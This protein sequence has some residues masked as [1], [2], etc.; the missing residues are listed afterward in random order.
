[1]T[2][3]KKVEAIHPHDTNFANPA[4]GSVRLKVFYRLKVDILFPWSLGNLQKNYNG[5]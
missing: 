5:K 2:K 1:M 3:H 4:I